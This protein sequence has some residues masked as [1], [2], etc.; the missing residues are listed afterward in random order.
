MAYEVIINKKYNH[1][2]LY[3]I[4]KSVKGEQNEISKIVTSLVNKYLLKKPSTGEGQK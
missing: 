4:K 2:K 3:N 1:V